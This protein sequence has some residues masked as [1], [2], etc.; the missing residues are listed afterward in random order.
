MDEIYDILIAFRD[1]RGVIAPFSSE[2]QL[3]G[4]NPFFNAFGL[5]YDWYVHQDGRL[6]YG[7][8]EP[9]SRS[10]AEKMAQWYKKDF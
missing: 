7:V 3:I 5:G 10:Y 9:A 4:Y 2:K 1:R 6:R 8:I